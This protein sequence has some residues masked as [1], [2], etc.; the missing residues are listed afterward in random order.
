MVTILLPI[1]KLSKLAE[2]PVNIKRNG[3]TAFGYK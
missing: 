3:D 2:H 1:L